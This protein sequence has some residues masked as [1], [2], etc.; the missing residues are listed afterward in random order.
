M[1]MYMYIYIYVC[2][3]RG[4]S[5]NFPIMTHVP[6]SLRGHC[7]SSRVPCPFWRK[8]ARLPYPS[9]TPGSSLALLPLGQ[10]LLGSLPTTEQ[11]GTP[12]LAK[13]NAFF[14]V[15]V[16]PDQLQTLWA[17]GGAPA[18]GQA[19]PAPELQ[20]DPGNRNPWGRPRVL[21]EPIYDMALQ[22]LDE[23]PCASIAS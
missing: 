22:L 15:G 10:Q 5:P 4:D 18:P 9:R 7:K 2:L 13:R 23:S 21:G 17:S 16:E 3:C 14:G 8:A 11:K 19:G 1:Y 12:S 20:R 6:T